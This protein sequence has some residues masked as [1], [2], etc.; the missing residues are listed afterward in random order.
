MSK[1]RMIA[2]WELNSGGYFSHRIRAFKLAR[3]V[4]SAAELLDLV[5]GNYLIVKTEQD[6]IDWLCNVYKSRQKAI[7]YSL[8]RGEIV[9]REYR[10]AQQR[11][12]EDLVEKRERAKRR[13]K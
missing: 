10:E 11:K 2:V 13:R 8:L 6:A 4:Q 12:L 3:D 9:R 7:G 5:G 1:P